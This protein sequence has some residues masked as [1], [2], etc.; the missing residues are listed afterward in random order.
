MLF[1]ACAVVQLVEVGDL[2]VCVCV[3]SPYGLQ[4]T[5]LPAW[6]L[7]SAASKQLLRHQQ[8]LLLAHPPWILLVEPAL[9]GARQ[10]SETH[11][12][13]QRPIMG[14]LAYDR[15]SLHCLDNCCTCKA[16]FSAA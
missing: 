11:C 10:D 4:A 14:I 5:C 12:A 2:D 7:G 1:C 16:V 15:H 13:E 3:L 9:F 8:A 6:V